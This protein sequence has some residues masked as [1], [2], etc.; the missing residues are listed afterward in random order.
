MRILCYSLWKDHDLGWTV[1]R[2]KEVNHSAIQAQNGNISCS[3]TFFS[4]GASLWGNVLTYLRSPSRRFILLHLPHFP[5]FIHL[6]IDSGKKLN[7]C[8]IA[9]TAGYLLSDL[10]ALISTENPSQNISKWDRFSNVSCFF[11]SVASA[12]MSIVV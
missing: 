1:F 5:L 11:S 3:A 10:S 2:L 4:P 12:Y 7:C 9:V 8:Q 6:R